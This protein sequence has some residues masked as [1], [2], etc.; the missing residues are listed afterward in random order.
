MS[1]A[2]PQHIMTTPQAAAYL[3]LGITTLEKWRLVR[4]NGPKFLRLGRAIRYRLKDLDAWLDESVRTSTSDV[5]NS[6]N[7][8]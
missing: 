2:L 8:R 4:N 5:G 6:R 7:A 1:T 3:G